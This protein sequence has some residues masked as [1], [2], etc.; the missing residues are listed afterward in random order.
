MLTFIMDLQTA[1]EQWPDNPYL[2][3]LAMDLLLVFHHPDEEIQPARGSG[4]SDIKLRLYSIDG[5]PF[6]S[7]GLRV[8][9][10]R[11]RGCVSG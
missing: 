11:A 6:R 8:S 10:A 1:T 7:R 5:G 2:I 4:A 3:Q 9:Q